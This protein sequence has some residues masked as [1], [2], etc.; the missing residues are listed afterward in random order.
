MSPKYSSIETGVPG[1]AFDSN[2]TFRL[3]TLI[4]TRSGVAELYL[5]ELKPTRIDHV[6]PR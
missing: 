3:P 5:G 6:L 1:F 2:Q 4:H